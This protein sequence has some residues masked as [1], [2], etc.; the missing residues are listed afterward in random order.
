[1]VI[2]KALDACTKKAKMADA[3]AYDV[4]HWTK[5]PCHKIAVVYSQND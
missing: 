4:S 5:F 3:C 1:V 2:F